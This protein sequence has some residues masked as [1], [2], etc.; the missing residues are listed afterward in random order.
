MIRRGIVDATLASIVIP[1]LL[2][3][4][5]V[6]STQTVTEKLPNL[7][8][9][10]ASELHVVNDS[11]T[12]TAL[13]RFSTVSY[14]NGI[15]PVELVGGAFNLTTN[16]Q[17]VYQRVYLS[18]GTYYDR[19]A[20][21]FIYHPE[22]Q[23]IHFEGYATYKLLPVNAPGASQR[24]GTKTSFCLEDTNHVL[25]NLP[26]SPVDPAY[27]VCNSQ[28]QG[29]SVG[30]ADRYGYLLAGQSIDVTGLPDGDYQLIIEVDPNNHLL[31]QSDAD[32]Q[33]CILIRLRV[34]QASAQLLGSCDG[35][36]ST[37]VSLSSISPNTI[38]AG[39]ST[40]VTVYGSGFAAGM[41]LGFEN[42]SGPAPVASNVVVAADG[43]TITAT[44]SVKSGGGKRPRAWDV[45]VSSAVLPR[46]FTVLP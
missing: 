31:E 45:R 16:T 26:G 3:F 21:D 4:P 42:G 24:N 14:N 35:G 32:N 19:L 43:D 6:G 11:V 34:A 40:Q 29:I 38:K 36:G 46:A 23:H 7:V 28:I 44:V 20:G 22:H 39:T 5:R 18:D 33:S 41:S 17:K 2:L 27:T 8:P 9:Y 12:G 30:W 10:P 25:P 1:I 15:G 13:L 37:T